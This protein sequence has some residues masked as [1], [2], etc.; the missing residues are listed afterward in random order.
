MSIEA[1]KQALEALEWG[2]PLI[3]DYGSKEQ[4][5]AHLSAKD[6]LYKA[7]EADMY[8]NPDTGN[9]CEGWDT[10][11]MA[12]RPGGLSVEQAENQA[13]VGEIIESSFFD[14]TNSLTYFYKAQPPVGTK[15]YTAPPASDYHEGWEEGFK[16]AQLEQAKPEPVTW[17]ETNDL[18]CALLRQA[19]DVLACASYPFKRPWVGLTDEEIKN[20]LDCGRG[21]LVD[22]KKA[23][24]ILREKNHD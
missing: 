1:M 13:P 16:A 2:Q 18:V 23:E 3:E 22:I 17:A 19:H 4:L 5:Q 7:I 8:R 12:H 9:P 20:I 21:G 24:Q 10:S 6:A 11:D 15:L 14:K